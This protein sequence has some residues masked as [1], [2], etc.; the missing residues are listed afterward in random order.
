MESERDK[1]C[2]DC[3]NTMRLIT[4]KKATF[5]TRKIARYECKCGFQRS[6]EPMTER[7]R[8]LSQERDDQ[9]VEIGIV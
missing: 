6:Y 8:R 3:G 1:I 2:D 5:K 9:E 4:V 7:D